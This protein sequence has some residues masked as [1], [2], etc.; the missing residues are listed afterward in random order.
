M[1]HPGPQVGPITV[2]PSLDN[3]VVA[4]TGLSEVDGARGRLSYRGRPILEVAEQFPTWT[5]LVPWLVTGRA[6]T[7]SSARAAAP[8]L[9]WP[10]LSNP[11]AQLA[12]LILAMGDGVPLD[13]PEAAAAFVQA[14][15]VWY[16]TL[17]SPGVT[18]TPHDAAACFLEALTGR[19]PDPG[20]VAALNAYWV[21]AAEHNLNASTFAVR[22]AAS[23]GAQLPQALAAGVAALSGPLH[24]GA[25]TGVLAQLQALEAAPDLE[26]ALGDLLERGE[27]VMGFG[28]RVY[29]TEDPRA[30]CLR[31]VLHT[32]TGDGE[33]KHAAAVES[34]AL[35]VLARWKP[36]RPLAVNVEFY[37]ALVLSAL[38]I[39][40]EDCPAVFACARLAGWAAHYWEQRATGRL[41]RPLARYAPAKPQPS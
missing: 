5:Q 28:H 25:P 15:P 34:A 20:A 13:T 21:L 40:A 29:R 14:T 1:A 12:V 39:S 30:A 41:I 38:G 26:V 18:P 23:T 33:A 24:G 22:V 8:E 19:R 27:R 36:D 17:R 4:T 32:L 37:A 9:V 10:T 3:V 11:L 7:H 35:A 6:V 2:P 31:G 16:A